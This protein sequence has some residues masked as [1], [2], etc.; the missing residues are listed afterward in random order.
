LTVMYALGFLTARETLSTVCN[1]ELCTLNKQIRHTDAG[2]KIVSWPGPPIG[3]A[4]RLRPDQVKAFE[5]LSLTLEEYGW[6]A[7]LQMGLPVLVYLLIAAGLF[8]R[9]SD[10]WMVLF[11]SV[12]VATIPVGNGP[13]PF[14]LVA[15]QPAWEWVYDSVN[16][17]GLSCFL[18]FPLIFPTGRFVPR[19]T[20]WMA[21]FEIVGAIIIT[22][23]SNPTLA[24]PRIKSLVVV[25]L[26]IS[27]GTGVYAQLYRYFRMASLV[28]RQ[29]LK[30]VV[31]GLVGFVGSAFTVLLPLN[32]L[33]TSQAAGMDAAR[34]LLL[35]VIPDTLFQLILL[36]I[37]VS[38]AIS[39]LRYRLW[40]ID[41]II[42]RTIVYGALTAS[43]V[44]IYALIVGGFGILFQTQNNLLSI[45]IA[46]L[47]IAF[48]FQPLRRRLQA[49]VNRFVPVPLVTSRSQHE[50]ETTN[51]DG[52]T[53]TKFHGRWL[54]IARVTWIALT[55]LSVG[56]FIAAIPGYASEISEYARASRNTIAPVWDIALY[57]GG[58]VASI[59]HIFS[60]L[61]PSWADRWKG[62][63]SSGPLGKYKPRHLPNHYFLQ[64]QRLRC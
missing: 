27:F 14:I 21:L 3:Y 18:I 62:Q 43:V 48:L 55:I 25:Y 44:A 33:L 52:T 42:N 57:I 9:K 22:L 31:V 34:A 4:D 61:E 47:L 16:V 29:Q 53:D 23:F 5:T 64:H 49:I 32:A 2:E 11:A 7:A 12:M 8:W 37:P 38:I 26:L 24:S 20:R 56:L 50:D 41:I 46:I 15:R 19:W 58:S 51:P 1:E 13:L 39:V 45:I 60:C 30:W 63:L 17:V 6:L 10:D 28:E 59:A 40:D 54:V 35:S 36:F